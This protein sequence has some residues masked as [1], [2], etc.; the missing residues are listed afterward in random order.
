MSRTRTRLSLIALSAFVP[1]AAIACGG[2]D[3]D[4]PA[5]TVASGATPQADSPNTTA[6][7]TTTSAGASATVTTASY[8]DAEAA[9]R[10]GKYAEAADGFGAYTERKP[11]NP[12]GFYMLG[13]SAWKAGDL[14]RADRAFEQALT[15]DPAHVKSLINS[16]RV[17]LELRHPADALE[18]A[19]AARD[20]DSTSLDALRLIARAQYELGNIDASIEAYRQVL[21][22]NERDVWAMNN[23]GLIYIEQGRFEEALPPLARAVE[24]KSTAPVFQNNLGIALERSGRYTAAKSAFEAALTAD[25][26]YG[27]ASVSLVRVTGRTDAVDV[28]P[29]DLPALAQQFTLQVRMWRDSA[30]PADSTEPVTDPV[31]VSDSATVESQH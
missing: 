25:S 11:E 27:K 6:A 29:V 8:E 21:V 26:T 16:S 30:T 14:A 13:L 28:T 10:G 24:L 7:G 31:V 12:W 3:R 22:G 5:T 1:L 19:E 4:K 18:R 2:A 9:F 23:L 20:I 15:L 17:L